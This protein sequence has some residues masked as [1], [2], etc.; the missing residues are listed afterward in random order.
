MQ[1]PPTPQTPAKRSKIKTAL[2][3]LGVLLLAFIVIFLMADPC[4]PGE[5]VPAGWRAP[6]PGPVLEAASTTGDTDAPTKSDL[7]GQ[8]VSK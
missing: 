1:S 3:V 6:A 8:A 7:G 4:P 5:P 2:I